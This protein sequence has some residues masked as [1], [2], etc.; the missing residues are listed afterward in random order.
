MN[1]HKIA[2]PTREDTFF[3]DVTRTVTYF[4]LRKIKTIYYEHLEELK[5]EKD[6]HEIYLTQESI[7][8]LKRSELSLLEQLKVVAVR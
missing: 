7:L 5:N 3:N 4:M 1:E 6:E 2:V 8:T